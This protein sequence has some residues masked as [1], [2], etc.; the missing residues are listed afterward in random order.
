MIVYCA[1]E[2]DVAA[3][4]TFAA[5]RGLPLCARAGGH[6]TSGASICSGGVVVDVS[7]LDQV[8][9]LPEEGLVVAGAG[10][11]F[12]N[13]LAELALYGM[14]AVTGDCSSVGAPPR[15]WRRRRRPGL[16]GYRASIAA[17]WGWGGCSLLSQGMLDSL[18]FCPSGPPQAWL[19]TRWAAGGAGSPS[20]TAWAPT[21]SSAWRRGGRAW[22]WR[23]QAGVLLH[24]HPSTRA[25]PACLPLCGPLRAACAQ[26][27]LANGTSV[28]ADESSH[29]DLYW[30][31]RGAGHQNFGIA[32]SI[33]YR[34]FNIKPTAPT[35]NVTFDVANGDYA[36]AARALALW[37]SEYVD[38]P[39]KEHLVV[40]PLFSASL[41]DPGSRQM[42]LL[43]V[44]WRGGLEELEQMMAPLAALGTSHAGE[45][46]AN[47]EAV[48]NL[49]VRACRR[50]APSL[51][52]LQA[53]AS[54]CRCRCLHT[55]AGVRRP[56]WPC[57]RPRARRRR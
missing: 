24:A 55:C 46:V 9:V 22:A 40:Q 14:G 18:A 23:G 8:S 5:E 30:A 20:P 11:I 56:P 49:G 26:V 39:G 27:V 33:T 37:R 47:P 29:P 43:A 34:A 2:A 3:A 54:R 50:T 12:Q 25:N 35:Y 21:T 53:L 32:T 38:A 41:G 44:L 36:A 19:A 28:T 16:A 51:Q 15:W 6:D 48:L 42:A 52:A 1:S 57:K 45:V 4:V 17:C 10:T 31:M 7:H 13:L